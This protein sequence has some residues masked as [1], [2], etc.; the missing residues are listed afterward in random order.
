[1]LVQSAENSYLSLKSVIPNLQASFVLFGIEIL[2]LET[3]LD[4]TSM[5]VAILQRSPELC[6]IFMN[7]QAYR[8]SIDVKHDSWTIFLLNI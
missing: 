8:L 3:R 6:G 4:I 2:H 5:Y 1:M 7:E